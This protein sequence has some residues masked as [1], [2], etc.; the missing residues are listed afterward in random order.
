MIQCLLLA[1]HLS[2]TLDNHLMSTI[3]LQD[4]DL[5]TGTIH[6]QAC[7]LSTS[8]IHLQGCDLSTG[9]IHLQACVLSTG[10]LDLYT[11]IES[12]SCWEAANYELDMGVPNQSL[13]LIQA[14]NKY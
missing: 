6:L 8:A 9:T 4:Y 3:H 1:G 2:I 5:S 7:D 11:G 14:R 10:L 13:V 12:K